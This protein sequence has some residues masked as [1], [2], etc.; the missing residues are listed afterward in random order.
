MVSDNIPE[1]MPIGLDNVAGALVIYCPPVSR[2]EGAK[3][4][5]KIHPR[6]GEERKLTIT[7]DFYRLKKFVTL[8]ADVLFVSGIPFLFTF[9]IKIRM[10][11][12]EYVPSCTAKKL[13]NYLSKIVI[14]YARGGFIIDLALMEM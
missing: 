8:T 14:T 9:S 2:L 3:T 12:V 11:T 1:N 4:R 10:L 13:A 6:V 7:R 5:E